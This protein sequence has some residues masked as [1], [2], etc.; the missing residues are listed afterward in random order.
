M[1]VCLSL[2][3]PVIHKMSLYQTGSDED[4]V[5]TNEGIEVTLVRGEIA[6]QRVRF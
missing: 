1:Y 6:K 4:T 5:C 2:A 3:A